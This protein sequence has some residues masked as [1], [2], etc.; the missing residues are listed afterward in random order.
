M[1]KYIKGQDR[2]QLVLF[3]TS[4]EDMIESDNE[5][6]VIDAFVEGLDIEKMGIKRSKPNAEGRRGYDPRD[7]LKIYL[8]GYR[9][10]IRS[11]RKLMKLC[12]TNV[13]MMWLVKQIVPDFRCI[14]DF[15]KEHGKLL[16]KVFLEFNI[17]CK[18]IGILEEKEVSQDGT[19]IKAVNSK[20]NN[21][22]LNKVDDRIERLKEKIEEYLK[23]MEEEDKKENKEK[24]IEL[25]KLKK[26]KE[27]Y[28]NYR[29]E[30]ERERK[31]QKSLTDKESKLMKN[32][33]KF[34]VC[35]NMQS[36]VSTESH[37]VV[38]YKITDRPADFGSMSEIIEGAEEELEIKIKR[39]ITD[40]GYSDR[41][42]MMKCL[43]NG[44]IPEVTPARGKEEYILET[45][46]EEAE[47]SEEE[48][49]SR[50]KEDI[51]KVLRAGEV[52]EIY[53]DKIEIIGIKN[54]RVKEEKEEDEEQIKEEELR[55]RAMKEG[56][57]IRDKKTD[58][59]YCPGGC[60]L[61]KKSR[62]GEGYKY[63]NK[64]GC[65]NCKNPCTS[66]AYKEVVFRKDQTEVIPNG[67]KRTKKK[68]NKRKTKDVKKVVIKLKVD[69]E[70]LKRRMR[71]S[72]HHHGSMKRWDDAGYC[73]L[74]GKEKVTGEVA[75]Y[76]CCYN[77]RRAINILGVKELIEKMEEVQAKRRGQEEKKDKNKVQIFT[78]NAKYVIIELIKT[79]R[80]ELKRV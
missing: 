80:M 24:L 34:E 56:I 78:K 62:H 32:N 7:M 6:R 5:I 63:C 15:R 77:I 9:N 23:E 14:S 67:K 48:K 41:E 21:F 46:Y 43:E 73:L 38:D 61:R 42:D 79:L 25:E 75:L 57:F 8:Y 68:A 70:V 1:G 69:K 31:S 27:Q 37:M 2:N 74:K 11:S 16:R 64:L 49:K 44:T 50:K 66:S 4:I 30:M 53:K 17:I 72:E 22:T 47:I 60:I 20:E 36:I 39:N 33:G 10:R 35:Y 76:L 54:K 13:E 3:Q 52:P 71:T 65:K 19:K 40:N 29:D 55:E 12:K 18:E 51:K 28:E 26:R 58:K 45:E 59:V